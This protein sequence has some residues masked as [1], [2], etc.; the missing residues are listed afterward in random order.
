[1]GLGATQENVREALP[2]ISTCV[3]DAGVGATE[4][5]ALSRDHEDR[6]RDRLCVPF[7]SFRA[8]WKLMR[9]IV[10]SGGEAQD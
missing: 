10:A 6:G 9:L 5:E 4:Y 7:R 2:G 8:S 1:M 3:W